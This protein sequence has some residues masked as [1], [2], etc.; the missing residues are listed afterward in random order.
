MMDGDIMIRI[1][2]LFVELLDMCV[3]G[4]LFGRVGEWGGGE[5]EIQGRM[6]KEGWRRREGAGERGGRRERRRSE[7][8]EGGGRSM[9]MERRSGWSMRGYEERDTQTEKGSEYR[10]K[11]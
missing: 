3:L 5:G 7:K 10:G 4:G 11:E 1:V 2:C 6:E 8:G 9:R